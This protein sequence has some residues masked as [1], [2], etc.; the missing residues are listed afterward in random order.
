MLGTGCFAGA[1][2]DAFVRAVPLFF[3]HTEAPVFVGVHVIQRNIVPDR[4]NAR[5]VHAVG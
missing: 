2:G 1:A 3:G 4:E 5:N